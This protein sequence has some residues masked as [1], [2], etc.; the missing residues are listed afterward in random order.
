MVC[1]F[2][3]FIAGGDFDFGML[4]NLLATIFHRRMFANFSICCQQF[5]NLLQSNLFIGYGKFWNEPN[6]LCLEKSDISTCIHSLVALPNARFACSNWWWKC[7]PK[8]ETQIIIIGTIAGT[9][10]I[11]TAA[12]TKQHHCCHTARY[13]RTRFIS[14]IV[15]A[16]IS[17]RIYHSISIAT[18]APITTIA[19][20]RPAKSARGCTATKCALHFR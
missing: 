10:T 19:H 11:S 18:A 5:A 9:I 16:S 8:H 3:F 12:H 13:Y 6:Y 7:T 2:L 20:T 4:Y 17:I 15:I 1:S 14:S